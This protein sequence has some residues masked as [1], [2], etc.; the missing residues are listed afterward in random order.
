[1]WSFK[2]KKNL[3]IQDKLKRE[4]IYLLFN[5]YLFLTCQMGSTALG[6]VEKFL[7]E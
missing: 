6:T 3:K 4:Y 1:M 5:K 2:I 7:N